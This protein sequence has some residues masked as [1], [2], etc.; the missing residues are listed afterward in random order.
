MWFY[1]MNNWHGSKVNVHNWILQVLQNHEKNYHFIYI[2]FISNTIA[3]LPIIIQLMQYKKNSRKLKIVS[4]RVVGSFGALLVSFQKWSNFMDKTW[5]NTCCYSRWIIIT[6]LQ[7]L[8]H[9]HCLLIWYCIF[10]WF[11]LPTSFGQ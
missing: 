8:S 5:T 10:S 4:E 9:Y 2:Y 7:Y 3:T 11:V 6:F 1:E